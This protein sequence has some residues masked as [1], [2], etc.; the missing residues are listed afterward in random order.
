MSKSKLAELAAQYVAA[1][2]AEYHWSERRRALAAAIQEVTGWRSEGSRTF[3]DQCWK[4]VVKQPM[5]RN[6]NWGV[7]ENIKEQIPDALWPVYHKPCLDEKGVKW[8]KEMEPGLYAVLAKALTVKPGAV[9]ITVELDQTDEDTER[10]MRRV[11]E[12]LDRE[13]GR[14]N[15]GR[16]QPDQG[17][18]HGV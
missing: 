13:A 18:L 7:W 17:D 3:A 11:G 5:N 8:L 10:L 12:S 14:A 9:Q 16:I 1:K 15:H 4:V 6:M 2:E